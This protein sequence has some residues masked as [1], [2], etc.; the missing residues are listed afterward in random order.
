M[1]ANSLLNLLN[2]AVFPLEIMETA[3]QKGSINKV[4]VSPYER[5]LKLWDIADR[6]GAMQELCAVVADA[7]EQK[8]QEQLKV[9]PKADALKASERIYFTAPFTTPLMICFWQIT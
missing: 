1:I 5:I 9:C 7:L 2:T 4:V 6:A 3:I 8:Y